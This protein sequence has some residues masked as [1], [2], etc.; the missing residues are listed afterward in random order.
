MS[1]FTRFSWGEMERFDLGKKIDFAT[2]GVVY[3]MATPLPSFGQF[4][5][6]IFFG[7]FFCK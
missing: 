2:L 3:Q 6:I 7:A 4:Y 5:L 1:Q